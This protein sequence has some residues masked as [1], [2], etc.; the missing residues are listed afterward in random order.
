MRNY[1]QKKNKLVMEII[2]QY[3]YSRWVQERR[4]RIDQIPEPIQKI[5]YHFGT[6]A[7]F[8]ASSHEEEKRQLTELKQ[9]RKLLKKYYRKGA[10]LI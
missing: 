8:P 4:K 10:W 1:K 2:N 5:Y 6:L 7:E 9:I 3:H